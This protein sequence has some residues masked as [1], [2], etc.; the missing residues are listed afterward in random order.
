MQEVELSIMS[1]GH[2]MPGRNEAIV[3]NALEIEGKVVHTP[4]A[5]QR[6]FPCLTQVQWCFVTGL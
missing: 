1:Q 4:D 6:M 5:L 2:G 3:E